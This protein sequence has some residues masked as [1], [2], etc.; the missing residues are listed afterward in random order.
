[1]RPT[2]PTLRKRND[3]VERAPHPDC[4]LGVVGG[5]S[6]LAKQV[7]EAED[8]AGPIHSEV[9]DGAFV[10]RTSFGPLVVEAIRRTTSLPLDVHLMIE[11]PERQIDQFVEAG[12]LIVHVELTD[13]VDVTLAKVSGV[14]RCPG[15]TTVNDGG[16]HLHFVPPARS[17][18][19]PS[20]VVRHGSRQVQLG[21][22]DRNAPRR[23]THN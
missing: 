3:G 8:A 13:D 14:H 11:R 22:K 6:R 15:A 9:M 10:P 7:R 1:M 21:S 4:A 16:K 5:L 18:G 12:A 23:A 2:Q 20:P 19:D 17:V